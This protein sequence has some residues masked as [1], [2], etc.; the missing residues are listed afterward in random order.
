MHVHI[1]TYISKAED[2]FFFYISSF[3][4]IWCH[5]TKWGSHPQN[6]YMVNI[7]M[8]VASMP[9]A[10]DACHDIALRHLR[11]DGRVTPMHRV[12]PPLATA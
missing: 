8:T 5:S 7:Y 9:V 6:T 3:K 11:H 4:K 2:H 1:V 10:S 12:H